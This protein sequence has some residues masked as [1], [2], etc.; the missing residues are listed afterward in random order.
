M[1]RQLI[2]LTLAAALLAPLAASAQTSVPPPA[3]PAAPTA[4]LS[5]RNANHVSGK[6]M[7]VDATAKTVTISHHKKSITLSVP[8]SAKI[9]KIGDTRKNP[10]GTFADLTVDAHIAARTNGDADKL[11]A[12]Q[13]RLQAPKNAAPTPPAAPIAPVPPTPPAAP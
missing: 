1:L 6:I 7:S 13:V 2:P 8:D 11:V 10:T 3:A 12:T 5:P 4:P 9:F